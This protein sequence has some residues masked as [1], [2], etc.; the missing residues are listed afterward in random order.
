MTTFTN[1]YTCGDSLTFQQDSALADTAC[2]TVEV[3]DREMPDF[4]PP[5]CLVL[6]Q[7]TFFISESDKA[8]HRSRQQLTAPVQTSKLVLTL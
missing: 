3:L 8:H 6:A 2:E 4:M 7:C 1:S 5:Y